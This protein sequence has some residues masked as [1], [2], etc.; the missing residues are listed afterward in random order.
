MWAGIDALRIKQ[1]PEIFLASSEVS[2]VPD[3]PGSYLVSAVIDPERA[4]HVTSSCAD[5]Y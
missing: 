2:G 4:A 3:V 5:A 1:P